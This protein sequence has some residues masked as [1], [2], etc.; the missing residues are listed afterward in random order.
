MVADQV[1]HDYSV[2]HE[3]ISAHAQGKLQSTGGL[4]SRQV[5]AVALQ[6]EV[7]QFILC[8]HSPTH[9]DASISQ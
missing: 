2:I 6:Q 4:A 5:K 9:L 3:R 8:C 1:S 7:L